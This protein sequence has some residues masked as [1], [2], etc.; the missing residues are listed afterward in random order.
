MTFT[1]K[2]IKQSGFLL[3]IFT[4]TGN[5][6]VLPVQNSPPENVGIVNAVQ[7]LLCGCAVAKVL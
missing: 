1:N 3:S 6:N 5:M 2:E 7:S 4:L